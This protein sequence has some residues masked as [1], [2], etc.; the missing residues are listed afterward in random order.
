MKF[1]KR[2]NCYKAS[3][4]KFIVDENS[5]YSYDWWCFFRTINGVN[6][7]NNYSYSNT[8]N[9]HQS[10]V[11]ALLRELNINIDLV[12]ETPKSLNDSSALDK[13]IE[14]YEYRIKLLN[15]AINKPRS[16]KKKNEERREQI[17][18][19][20][21]MIKTVKQLQ[22]KSEVISDDELIRGAIESGKLE[23]IL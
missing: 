20:Q 2:S 14:L 7:F 15:E 17:K 11:R 9:K 21:T 3:N 22:Q 19:L 23:I 18:E 12:I 16:Q 8:T 4:V 6:V 10:K 13:S 5:A 1:F